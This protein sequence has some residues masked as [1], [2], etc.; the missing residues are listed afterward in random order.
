MVWKT[1]FISVA[2]ITQLRTGVIKGKHSRKVT[3]CGKSDFPYPK[4]LHA[5]K[6]RI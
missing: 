2:H 4:E 5:K 6:E 3:L 1:S